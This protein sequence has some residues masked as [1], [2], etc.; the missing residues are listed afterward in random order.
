MIEVSIPLEGVRAIDFYGVHNARLG[1]IKK[2][3]PYLNIAARGNALTV[4]GIQHD[5]DDFRDK[6]GNVLHHLE[7]Y[8]HISDSNLQSLLLGLENKDL[9]DIPAA[10]E[11][12]IVHGPNGYLIKARTPNQKVMVAVAEENDIMFAIGPAGTGKTYTAVALAVRALKEKKVKR[13]ILTRPAVE[14][15]ENLGFLPGDLK[16]KIDPYLRPLYDALDDMIPMEKLQLYMTNRVIEIAP[17]AFMRGRTLD[18]AFIILDEAQNATDAQLK[19]FLTRIG[20][21]A[22]CI[23]TGDLTQVDLPRNMKS[24]LYTGLRILKDIEGIGIVFLDEK[25]VVRHKLVKRIIKAY[26]KDRQVHDAGNDHSGGN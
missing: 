24:G 26:D 6:I 20:P 21:S 22:K 2:S 12:V 14:A 3:F 11:D 13:I 15:G 23:I 5:I 7:K 8:G 1:I 10:P 16:E 19:M 18:N 4:R 9:A 25:D 17:L